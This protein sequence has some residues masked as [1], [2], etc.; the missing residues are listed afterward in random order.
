[1]SDIYWNI[2]NR[3]L[4][5][6][7]LKCILDKICSIFFYNYYCGGHGDGHG[8]GHGYGHGGGGGG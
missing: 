5:I 3:K 1:M 7:F 4:S 2:L 6:N 8:H